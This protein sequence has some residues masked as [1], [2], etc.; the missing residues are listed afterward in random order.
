M[1][2]KCNAKLAEYDNEHRLRAACVEIL[3]SSTQD[4][5]TYLPIDKIKDAAKELSVVHDIPLDRDTVD[6]CRD[7][8]TPV[9]AV[10][11]KGDGIAEL[12]AHLAA[13]A[14]A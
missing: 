10:T 14:A 12:R 7:D 2:P 11:G 6:I 9:V 1:P 5:H 3:E 13:L 4:G 8:F